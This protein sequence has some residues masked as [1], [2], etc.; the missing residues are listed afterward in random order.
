[1]A[2]RLKL[3]FATDLHG[4]DKCFRKFVNAGEA[5]GADALVLG[6]DVA[7]KAMAWDRRVPKEPHP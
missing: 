3:Y 5:Y 4:S 1:M 6:G 7:G 2:K